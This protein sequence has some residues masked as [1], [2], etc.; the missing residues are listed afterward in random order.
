M[1]SFELALVVVECIKRL[2]TSLM[3]V[4]SSVLCLY[5]TWMSRCE[6]SW[7]AKVKRFHRIFI[8]LKVEF[9]HLHSFVEIASLVNVK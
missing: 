6:V 3:P 2:A 7:L 8:E 5:A 1:I 4:I 9:F